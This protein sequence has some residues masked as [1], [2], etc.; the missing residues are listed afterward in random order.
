ME[1]A[2]TLRNLTHCSQFMADETPH[3][4]HRDQFNDEHWMTTADAMAYFKVSQRTLQ[5]WCHDKKVLYTLVGGTK[6]YP[7]KFIE[8][9]MFLKIDLPKASDK[10]PDLNGDDLPPHP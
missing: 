5:R 6:Y 8:R 9:L 3:N 7:K 1:K 4:S 10:G 2:C